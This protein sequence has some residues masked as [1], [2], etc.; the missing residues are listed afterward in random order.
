VDARTHVNIHFKHIYKLHK[1]AYV[2][3]GRKRVQSPNKD[4]VSQQPVGDNSSSSTMDNFIH[5]ICKQHICSFSL[6][7][8][9]GKRDPPQGIEGF[10]H[11]GGHCLVYTT[12]C[13]TVK[14][15]WQQNTWTYTEVWLAAT[16]L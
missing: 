2:Q 14:I 11:S 10:T 4:G 6:V 3:T 5:F 12:W 1:H 16:L 9:L 8:R 15:C 7:S 13:D